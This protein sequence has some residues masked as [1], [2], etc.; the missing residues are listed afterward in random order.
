MVDWIFEEECVIDVAFESYLEEMGPIKAIYVLR[1]TFCMTQEDFSGEEAIAEF[2][3]ARN[4]ML[5]AFRKRLIFL[6]FRL[7]FIAPALLFTNSFT[8]ESIRLLNL[9]QLIFDFL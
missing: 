7:H 5:K 9:L 8:Q 4:T 6:N 3:L 1:A 2:T